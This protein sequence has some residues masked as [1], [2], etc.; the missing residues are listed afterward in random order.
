MH[1]CS[2]AGGGQTPCR[3]VSFG[4]ARL[5]IF[6]IK[7]TPRPPKSPATSRANALAALML[8]RKFQ[9]A[10]ASYQVN[11]LLARPS[12]TAACC[13][14]YLIKGSHK[15]NAF[16]RVRC[17]KPALARRRLS[18]N[19]PLQTISCAAST[20]SFVSSVRESICVNTKCDGTN[21]ETVRNAH[22]A[23]SC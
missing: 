10:A 17:K 6:Q 16:E 14:L 12:R 15:I 3:R 13:A 2:P 5:L 20:F 22:A 8:M 7:L 18:V 21:R 19:A 9:E 11:P 1:T 23:S 4:L